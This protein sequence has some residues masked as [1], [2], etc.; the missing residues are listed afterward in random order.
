MFEDETILLSFYI[1]LLY[2]ILVFEVEVPLVSITL[3][4]GN[5]E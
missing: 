3:N 4:I 5:V 1:I 2:F